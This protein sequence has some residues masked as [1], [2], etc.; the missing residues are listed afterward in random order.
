MGQVKFAESIQRGPIE[1]LASVW[2]KMQDYPRWAVYESQ[3]MDSVAY[4]N[5]SFL[6]YGPEKEM[7]E[8]AERGTHWSKA[9]IGLVD[10]EGQLVRG[11]SR[12]IPIKLLPDEELLLN[13]EPA[14]FA[15]DQEYVVVRHRG[16][17]LER[18]EKMQGWAAAS[19]R[20]EE[21]RQSLKR[22]K[23]IADIRV[24]VF[25]GRDMLEVRCKG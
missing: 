21:L 19:R 11:F 14:H 1:V 9:L 7:K 18:L 12:D 24:Y 17:V 13:G 25:Y 15:L 23:N 10:L 6:L 5:V 8:P 16:A 3:A 22:G 4:G 20:A 2:K